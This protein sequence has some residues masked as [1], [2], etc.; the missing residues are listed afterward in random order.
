MITLPFPR[1][2]PYPRSLVLWEPM[3]AIKGSVVIS[4]GMAEHIGRYARVADRLNAAGYAVFGYNHLGHGDEAPIKG[5][6][7]DA[8]GWSNM[9]SDLDAVIRFAGKRIPGAPIILLGHSMGSF[10]A[11]EY[12]LRHPKGADALVLSGTGW[13]PKLL[14]LFGK[15]AAGSMCAL[16][17]PKAASRM[18][19]R[20]AFSANN[21]SFH[22]ARTAFD[23]LSRDKAEVDKY[24]ADPSCGFVFTAGGFRDLFCGLY[25]LTYLGRLRVL[26]AEFPVLL[27]SGA[28]DPVGSLGKGVHT[29]AGQYFKAGLQNVKVKLYAGARHELFNEINREEVYSDLTAWLNASLPPVKGESA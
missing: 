23:W 15:L 1:E 3:D 26:P 8:D 17:D 20:M 14:C 24:V 12:V 13:H 28:A 19:D 29:V 5:Y 6:A 16:G 21:K 22:P 18:L 7:A 9:V 2:G 27:I 4:H 11:R 10:L 25:A